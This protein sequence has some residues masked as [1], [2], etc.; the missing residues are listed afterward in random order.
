V[1]CNGQF[2]SERRALA[3]RMREA[4]QD[5]YRADIREASDKAVGRPGAQGTGELAVTVS[6]EMLRQI[7]P[8]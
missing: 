1:D 3:S 2:G 6:F 4:S 7:V 5:E 8:R